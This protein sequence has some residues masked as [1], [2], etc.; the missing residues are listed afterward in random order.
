MISHNEV[1]VY[2]IETTAIPANGIDYV[3]TIWAIGVKIGN[4]TT[5]KYTKYYVEGSDG[6]LQQALALINS[7]PYRSGH[8]ILGFDD[9]L[10]TK[11][12]GPL[13]NTPLDTLIL[14]KIIFSK[15]QLVAIDIALGED[16]PKALIGSY[17]LKA[18]GLRM[19][20]D[21]QKIEFE[22]WSKLSTD[23]IEYMT[24]D[25]EVS[26]KLI[27]FLLSHKNYPIDKVVK[28]EHDVRKIISEQEVLG[29]YIDIE[30]T[31]T[32]NTNLLKNKIQLQH[33][34]QKIFLPKMLKD[35]PIKSY[36]KA[37]KVRKYLPDERYINP[38]ISTT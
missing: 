2:D 31:R 32:L 38:W 3:S 6:T 20:G 33:K 22:D 15:D 16:Y 14:S 24:G 10:I 1:A 27:H 34:L 26:F 21:E 17:S 12:I 9:Y 23:M 28:I 8:N 25:V 7:L 36:K 11:F 5:K 18:F 13:T 29:F 4:N 30:L 19:G 37:S 35:G